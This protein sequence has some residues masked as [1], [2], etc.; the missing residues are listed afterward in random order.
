M[1]ETENQAMLKIN[2]AILHVGATSADNINVLH[3]SG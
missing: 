2:T 1:G 3:F